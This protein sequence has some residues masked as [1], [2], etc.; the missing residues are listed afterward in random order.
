VANQG[1]WSVLYEGHR[2]APVA[3]RALAIQYALERAQDDLVDAPPEIVAT[4]IVQEDD[5]Y[6]RE[7]WTSA[8][9]ED[10]A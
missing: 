10:A 8:V 2:S 3:D 9:G 4:V 5:T 7:Y 1:G 6:F